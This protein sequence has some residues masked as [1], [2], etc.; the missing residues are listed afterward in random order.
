MKFNLKN[1][2]EA[3]TFDEFKSFLEFCKI[4]GTLKYFYAGHWVSYKNDYTYTIK[5][6]NGDI[7]FKDGDFVVVD[8]IGNVHF[9][10]KNE[11]SSLYQLA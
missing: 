2:I 1:D 10:D 8:E 4:E 5:T 6:K 9:Y 7:D 11:F 3:Y